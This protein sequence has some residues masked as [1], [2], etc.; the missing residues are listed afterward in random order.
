[1]ISI[2]YSDTWNNRIKRLLDWAT[3]PIRKQ[4]VD[5]IAACHGI[6]T[7]RGDLPDLFESL[8]FHEGGA[9]DLIYRLTAW[10]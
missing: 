9:G 3:L 6:K 7:P 2:G 8:E 5:Y 10:M 1:V 4:R